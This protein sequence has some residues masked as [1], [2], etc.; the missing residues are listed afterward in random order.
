MTG[1]RSVQWN[2]PETL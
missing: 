2:T 1:Y